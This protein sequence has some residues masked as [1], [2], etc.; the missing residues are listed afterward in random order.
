[1]GYNFR[2]SW[3]RCSSSVVRRCRSASCAP[4][5]AIKPTPPGV[6]ASAI[7]STATRAPDWRR[8]FLAAADG[9]SLRDT[10]RI[11]ELRRL[12][13]WQTIHYCRDRVGPRAPRVPIRTRKYDFN[14]AELSDGDS[15]PEAG[16][17]VVVEDG[18]CL[19]VAEAAARAGRR[20]A[21]LNMADADTPGGVGLMAGSGAQEADLHRR[22]TL[23]EHLDHESRK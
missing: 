16:I 23:L 21:V 14:S 13:Q 20:V 4:D 17:N 7:F 3:S 2:L 18:D 5:P 9:A 11:V 6:S 10:G 12:V 19:V 22:T 1:M 8:R 15:A